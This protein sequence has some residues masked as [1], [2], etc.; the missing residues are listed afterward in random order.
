[1]TDMLCDQIAARIREVD[2][3]HTMGAGALGE[4][5]ADLIQPMLNEK[6]IEFH[7]I[8]QLKADTTESLGLAV[9]AYGMALSDD[10]EG[11]NEIMDTL[12]ERVGDIADRTPG[13]REAALTFVAPDATF[14]EVTAA[15]ADT[16]GV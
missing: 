10:L 2:G 4:A 6:D 5:I 3:D 9:L 15:L 16:L 14:D 1:M 13:A 8:V 7:N 11:A 12:I